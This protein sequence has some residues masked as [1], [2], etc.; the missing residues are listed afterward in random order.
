MPNRGFLD[1]WRWELHAA[2]EFFLKKTLC[3]WRDRHYYLFWAG[4]VYGLYGGGLAGKCQ[5]F[6][7]DLNFWPALHRPQQFPQIAHSS[8]HLL[9]AFWTAGVTA[10]PLDIG[11]VWCTLIFQVSN[12]TSVC[13]L[14]RSAR[15]YGDCME[16][17][18]AKYSLPV[19]TDL[20][21]NL[22]Q[23]KQ[24]FYVLTPVHVW[25]CFWTRLGIL[26]SLMWFFP[27]KSK[28]RRNYKESFVQI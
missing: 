20:T 16:D 23:K 19:L 4:F 26:R 3:D 12:R 27:R 8:D 10:R 5:S 21:E 7:R 18:M 9:C 2:R 6:G 22:I 24:L 11:S 28:Y 14:K 25:G 1:A 15:L 17:H 13:I